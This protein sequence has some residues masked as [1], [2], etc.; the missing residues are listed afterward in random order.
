[1]SDWLPDGESTWGG[2]PVARVVTE[3]EPRCR[4]VLSG[5]VRAVRVR[6]GPR[7]EVELDD[8]TGVVVLRWLGRESIPGLGVGALIVAEGTVLVDRG[9]PVLLNPLYRFGHSST[10]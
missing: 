1:M 4:A 8:G 6:V 3:L 10:S 9:R 7:L 2:R 5:R